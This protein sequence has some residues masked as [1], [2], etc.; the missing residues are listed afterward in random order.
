V[1]ASSAS[2][3]TDEFRISRH[4]KKQAPLTTTVLA[5]IAIAVGLT[6]IIE[7]SEPNRRSSAMMPTWTKE[8]TMMTENTS[9]PRGS[10]RERPMGSIPAIVSSRTAE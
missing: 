5:M 2:A 3:C 4:Q 9:T 6:V 7:C 8:V 1:N 10:R